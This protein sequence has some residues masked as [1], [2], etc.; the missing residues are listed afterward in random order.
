[1]R[2]LLDTHS[3]LWW[4]SADARLGP[5]A[6]EGIAAA[7][8]AFV[9]TASAWEMSIKGALGK[10][11]APSDLPQQLQRHRFTVLPIH[12][13]HALGVRALPPLHRDPFDRMLVAQAQAEDLLLVSADPDV[14][15]YDVHV[16]DAST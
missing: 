11:E 12:L 2:L 9:S 4:L 16:I 7:E 14:A 5:L 15:R 6:R 3:L 10:L 13:D 8:V 1:M